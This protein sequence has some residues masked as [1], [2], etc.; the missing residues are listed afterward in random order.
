[1]DNRHLTSHHNKLHLF[2]SPPAFS[3]ALN[4]EYKLNLAGDFEAHSTHHWNLHPHKS[5]R[6][7]HVINLKDDAL[8]KVASFLNINQIVAK[9]MS[10]ILF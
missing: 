2:C 8:Y 4:Q 6:W 9:T 3:A 10:Y 7:T 1:M 5:L